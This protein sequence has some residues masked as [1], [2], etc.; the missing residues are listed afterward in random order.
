MLA[1]FSIWMPR[2]LLHKLL[3]IWKTLVM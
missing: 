1:E 2:H 3:V